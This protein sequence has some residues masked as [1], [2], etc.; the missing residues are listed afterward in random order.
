MPKGGIGAPRVHVTVEAPATPP[1]VELTY[2][3]PVGRVSVMTTPVA[4]DG[5]AF[6]TVSV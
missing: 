1:P 6:V 2:V 3:S 5:P 4:V